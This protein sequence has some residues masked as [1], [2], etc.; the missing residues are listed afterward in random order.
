V[1]RARCNQ[2]VCLGEAATVIGHVEDHV[3]TLAG[4]G[5]DD[6]GCA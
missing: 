5:E 3:C 2:L 4:E 6:R 1:P